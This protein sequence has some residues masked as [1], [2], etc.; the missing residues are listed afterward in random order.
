MRL[1]LRRTDLP[2]E[3]AIMPNTELDQNSFAARW[4]VAICA[5]VVCLTLSGCGNGLAQVSGQVTLNGQPLQGGSGDT[6]VTVQFQPA[7][8]VG[9]TAIGLADE[10]GNYTLAT[11]SQNGIPPG[12]YYVTCTASQIVP[13]TT[14]GAP[15]GRRI[16][17]EKYASA[18]TSGFKFTVEPGRNTFDLPLTSVAS[19]KNRTKRGQ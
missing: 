3:R 11:G 6:R 19:D 4:A 5:I 15:G 2:V 10:T 9:V 13:S 18:R 8:G 17:P 1:L 7:G 16:T 14:G 12:D